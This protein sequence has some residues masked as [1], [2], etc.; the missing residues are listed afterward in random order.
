MNNLIKNANW[1]FKT[2]LKQLALSGS[3][4]KDRLFIQASGSKKNVS[5]WRTKINKLENG[6]WYKAS[7]KAKI[8]NLENTDLSIFAVAAKHLLKIKEKKN[9]ILTLDVEFIHD[10]KDGC[11]FDLF[12]RSADK[13]CVEYFE[14]IVYQINKPKHR[15]VRIA[16]IRFDFDHKLN[17]LSDQLKRIKEYLDHAGMLKPDIVL[18]TEFCSIQGIDKYF[19]DYLRAAE[20][21]PN[22]KTCRIFAEMGK[23][24]KMYV[25][26]G[27]VE[28]DEKYF[29]NTA[30]IF[31]R[32]GKPVGKYRKT[33]L[34]YTE[35]VKGISPG[36]EYTLFN[37]DFGKI[38]V[39]ICYDQWFPETARY[40]AHQGAEI[41]FEP[42]M[43]GKPIVWRTRAIDNGIYVVTAGW[44]PPSMIIE[45]SGK[46][47]AQTHDSGVACADIN[48]DYRQ[49]NAY[50]DPTLVYG[51]PGISPAMRMTENNNMIDEL[52]KLL[53][54]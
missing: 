24:Y 43:G 37:L 53:K 18:L 1:Q 33:H 13:G 12:L 34:T 23:K 14:P 40:F 4:K 5:W 17:E 27:I 20:E 26:G 39:Q 50:G 44:T 3:K 36:N 47:L 31:D 45:S 21:F 54:D 7:V 28:K 49:V 11:D 32:H 6:K 29:Y 41:L 9:N 16:T 30:V 52:Y 46:I 42:V 35:M 25:V 51:M 10:S 48:L 22:G 2:P 19:D 8:E 15:I 38:A